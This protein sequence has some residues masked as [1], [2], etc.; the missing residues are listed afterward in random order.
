MSK[1][2]YCS[3]EEA[4][5]E[6]FIKLKNDKHNEEVQNNKTTYNSQL[7]PIKDTQINNNINNYNNINKDIIN[8]NNNNNNRLEV[9]NVVNDEVKP[10]DI[11][12]NNMPNIQSEMIEQ[13]KN[14]N[15]GTEIKEEF[16]N[17]KS[18]IFELIILI[19]IGLIIIFVLDSVY[20]IGKSV[21]LKMKI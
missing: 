20:K 15:E 12:S 11:I 19:I 2:S 5:G 3:L 4:W 13:F 16:A 1:I 18:D 10:N 17:F 7:L 9:L 14:N 6:S 8:N 21:G